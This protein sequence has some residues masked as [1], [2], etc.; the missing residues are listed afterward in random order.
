MYTPGNNYR[1]IEKLPTLPADVMVLDLEDTIPPAEKETARFIVRDSIPNVA[2]SGAYVYC[3]INDWRTGLTEGDIE[4]IV[5]DGLDG[6]VLSKTEGREDV[7][8][9]DNKLTQLEKERG[10]KPGSVAI[11]CLIETAKGV[12][13][14]YES[15]IASKR[16]N[17]LVFG[18]VDYTRDMR[19]VLTK[20]GSEILVARC[21]TAIA[22]RA[23]GCI[24]IDPPYPA[25][26]DVEGF[27]KDSRAGRQ[28]GF[29][30]RMLIHPSQIEPANET[31]APTK[32]QTEYAKEVVK[33]F[34]EGMKAGSASVPLRGQMID[35]AVYRTQRDVLAAGEAVDAWLREKEERRKKRSGA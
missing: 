5:E 21:W 20:E 26:R 31:Y 35:V 28:F 9:L 24:A 19:I 4:T 14:A 17:S 33:V 6:V 27:I 29:E 11:Q 12:V 16:V 8:R 7:V 18:A 2:K 25:Y 32:E 23:A 22:A 1:M 30:G 15:A 3:R 34:E 13:N 10:L